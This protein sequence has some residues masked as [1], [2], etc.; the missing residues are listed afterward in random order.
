V[1][2]KVYYNKVVFCWFTLYDLQ[3]HGDSLRLK[4][5]EHFEDKPTV[6]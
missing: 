1:K 5:S 4:Q 2:I 6:R 3:S